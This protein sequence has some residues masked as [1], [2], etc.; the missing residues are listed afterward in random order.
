[1]SSSVV[2]G[3]A[4]MKYGIRY[5][6]LPASFGGGV[7]HLLEPVVGADARLHHL[8]ER[9]ALGVLGRDLQVAADVVGDQFLDVFRA[10]DREVVAQAGG[11]HDLLDALHR[12]RLA[13][14]P[15]QSSWSV[16]RFGQMSGKT[17]DGRPA[18]R[19]DL[20]VLAGHAVHVGGRPAE[21]GDDAGEARR[22]VADA[23]DLAQ[24]RVLRAALDDAALVLGD[25]A[26]GAAAEAAAHDV[27]REPDHVPGRD[28]RV[29]VGRDAARGRRAGRRPRP[30]RRWSAGSA[31]G[32]ATRRGRRGAAPAGARCRDWL[33]RCSTR[34][35]WA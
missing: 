5:C 31:A 33:S 16:L 8:V 20:R 15:D 24:D 28:L 32:S 14:E 17:Q 29:A 27:D 3:C 19:L 7:E 10:L 13:V 34:E 23:L 6:F 21:V 22:L 2:P 11:D 25:R 12:A 4:A 26:E 35:A 18:R 1:M 9:A 30:S